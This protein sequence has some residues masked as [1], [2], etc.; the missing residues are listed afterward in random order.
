MVCSLAVWDGFFLDTN[1]L[2]QK[3]SPLHLRGNLPILHHPRRSRTPRWHQDLRFF[4]SELAMRTGSVRT[5]G[6]DDDD[7]DDD[8]DG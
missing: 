6:F 1:P 4:F 7:D 2:K 8:D 5:L 3:S